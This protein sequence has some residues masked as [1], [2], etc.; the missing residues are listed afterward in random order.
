MKIKAGL[1]GFGYW[2]A[3]LLRNFGSHKDIDIKIICDHN[4]S[5]LKNAKIISPSSKTCTEDE[6][7]FA[8]KSIDFVII[9]TQGNSHYDL[10]RKALLAGKHVFVEKPF[11]M[12]AKE[13]ADLVSLNKESGMLIM[14]DHT[15]LFTPEYQE[16]KKIISENQLGKILHFFSLRADFGRFQR[17]VNILWHLMYH[18]VYILMDLFSDLWP[19]DIVAS[20][21]AHIFDS[22]EDT[23]M[24]S[25]NYSNGL[26]ADIVNNM[27]F[28]EKERKIIIT[29]DRAILSWNDTAPEGEKLTSVNKYAYRE[30]NSENISYSPEASRKILK[31]STRQALEY[32]VDYFV[33]CLINSK[34]PINDEKAALQSIQFLESIQTAMDSAVG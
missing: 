23:A 8:D 17:D 22:K 14:V 11:T 3:V 27:L 4:S 21:K 2:G 29:G 30:N 34:R 10:T 32:E 13:A 18:D 20:G 33:S 26:C 9:A 28:P 1:I 25:I 24:V 5:K 12:S 31:V 16:V 19:G 6:I 15:F 7:I